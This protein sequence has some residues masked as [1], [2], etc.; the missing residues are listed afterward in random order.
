MTLNARTL[1]FVIVGV[2]LAH[3]ADPIL[4]GEDPATPTPNHLIEAD[5]QHQAVM[6]AGGVAGWLAAQKV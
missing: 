1:G 4:S 5:A 3:Y 6:A 2:L